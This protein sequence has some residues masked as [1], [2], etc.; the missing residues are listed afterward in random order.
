MPENSSTE[1]SKKKQ[2]IEKI[3]FKSI[4]LVGIIILIIGVMFY[5][6][7][8]SQAEFFMIFIKG[9]FQ[10][11]LFIFSFL[12]SFS[13]WKAND[14]ETIRQLKDIEDCAFDFYKLFQKDKDEQTVFVRG[15][16]DKEAIFVYS[17]AIE[18][19]AIMLSRFSDLV[20]SQIRQ[21]EL[22]QEIRNQLDSALNAFKV[23]A[24]TLAEQLQV[25][26]TERAREFSKKEL[27]EI[28]NNLKSDSEFSRALLSVAIDNRQKTRAILDGNTHMKTGTLL[29]AKALSEGQS[30]SDKIKKSKK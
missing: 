29:K 3:D 5:L 6:E 14:K 13:I 18:N 20:E 28:T 27:D 23:T 30:D 11:L 21:Q 22:K 25:K 2:K 10:I 1:T 17:Q 19:H 8:G 7:R 24:N 15:E 4:V 9:F 16:N 26:M 12:L